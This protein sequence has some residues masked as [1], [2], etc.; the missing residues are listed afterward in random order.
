[1]IKVIKMINQ[2]IDHLAWVMAEARM[3]G[4]SAE[5]VLRDG[6]PNFTRASG[7]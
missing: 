5:T 4:H 2:L 7:R 1:M 3:R 6:L